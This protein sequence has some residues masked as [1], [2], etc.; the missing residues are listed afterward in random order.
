MLDKAFRE[1]GSA[2]N[3]LGSFEFAEKLNFLGALMRF[4]DKIAESFVSFMIWKSLVEHEDLELIWKFFLNVGSLR[5]WHLK[6]V[7]CLGYPLFVQELSTNQ[8]A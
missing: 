2:P 5:F 8:L 1:L 4:L 3:H 7:N 6:Q